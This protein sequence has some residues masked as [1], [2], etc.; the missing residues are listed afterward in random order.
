M[1]LVLP[2]R[3]VSVSGA[4]AAV[5]L[6]GAQQPISASTELVADLAPADFVLVD[7]G[8]ILRV[9]DAEEAEAILAIYADMEQLLEE[10]DAVR[11]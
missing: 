8:M 6:H 3:V 4:T 1:C 11:A 2:A 5:L 7:R 9:I 10:E